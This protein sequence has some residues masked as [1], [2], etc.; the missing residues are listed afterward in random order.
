MKNIRFTKLSLFISFSVALFL[1]ACDSNHP[2]EVNPDKG[3]FSPIESVAP[4]GVLE[5]VTWNLEWY[6]SEGHGPSD[7]FQ[8]TQ[9]ALQ[10][11]DSL[12]ADLYAFQ[13]ISN[14]QSLDELTEYMTDYQGFVAEYISYNQKMAF[15]YNTNTIDSVR[16]GPILNIRDSFKKEWKYYWANGREPFYFQFQYTGGNGD[17]SE[18]FAVVI[19]AKANTSDY[20]ESYQ[21]R[22]K[23]AEGLY[24]YLQDHKPNAK[25][26]L[27]GDYNDDVDES[28]YYEEQ[29][30]EE[31]YQKTPYDEFVSDGQNFSVITKTLSDDGIS[32]SINYEDIIDHIT[33]SNELFDEYI[34]GSVGVYQ[35]PKTYIS[36][37]GETTS[38]HL[39]VW[40]KFDVA[41]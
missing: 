28:I 15:V 38:D 41:K 26:I 13:E 12:G 34:D 9:N 21:R 20:Q 32:A 30:N 29:N 23:A 37:Y 35:A 39:P 5:T 3:K 11:I 10:V 19:H 40:V 17:T 31:V 14:Q 6:G 25:V 27:L 16:S 33:M 4:D 8:Q 1:S 22:Q 2:P 7:E 24:Y 18:Y 36:N